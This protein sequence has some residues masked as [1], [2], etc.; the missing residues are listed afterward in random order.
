MSLVPGFSLKNGD[1]TIQRELGRGGF[2]TA[3]QATL[4][5]PDGQEEIVAIKIGN[6]ELS[7][8]ERSQRE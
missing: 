1:Y 5:L 8:N 4:K 6:D 3:Y 7:D 2:G